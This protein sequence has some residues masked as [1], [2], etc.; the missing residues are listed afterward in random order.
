MKTVSTNSLLRTIGLMMGISMA[1]SIMACNRQD[2][3][4][5]ILH[6]ND[7][8][9]EVAGFAKMAYLRD[10]LQA[11]DTAYVGVVSSGDLFQGGIEGT[12]THGQQIVDIMRC[13]GY[14]A[15]VPGNHEFDYGTPRML[16]LFSQLGNEKVSCVNLSDRS[17]KFLFPNY[18]MHRYGRTKV[19]Y[20][21]VLTPTTMRDEKS[22]FITND[23]DTLYRLQTDEE[24]VRLTQEQV[25]SARRAGAKYVILLTHIGETD[26]PLTSVDLIQ[27]TYGVDAVLDGHTHSEIA[28][29][30]VK[31]LKG[32]DVPLTQTGT[33]FMN[34]GVV[35]IGRDGRVRT[36]L[37]PSGEIAGSS[38]SVQAVLDSIDVVNAPIKNQP[39]G[40]TEV[41]LTIMGDNGQRL[42]RKGETNGGNLA[43]D[44][45]R[46]ACGAQ[47]AF[48]NGGGI[49]NDYPIGEITFGQVINVQPF[50]NDYHVIEI[51]G[52]QLEQVV[53]FGCS[54]LKTENLAEN[55]KGELGDFV[56]PSGFR[57]TFS[58]P[59][60]KVLSLEV[61]N[62]TTGQYEPIQ[63]DK[64]YT[65]AVSQYSLGS[66]NDVMKNC[67]VLRYN[68]CV[69]NTA[70]IRYIQER[71]GGVVG[72]EYARPQ[73]RITIIR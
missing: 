63:P 60:D 3:P 36:Y 73:G 61:L 34:V 56:Q 1:W 58:V 42:V 39:V 9:C 6:D 62:E 16:E 44:A 15:V 52:R 10:A 18:V 48:V 53:A 2:K 41:R 51:T 49:R 14:D 8:H 30:M 4:I 37:K 66:Y 45:A 59:E 5:V 68:V 23:G 47:M 19:A 65:M 54:A 64:T 57:Y 55:K 40:R 22:A 43:A 38:K 72:Q 7:S 24:V 71:L 29:R 31:N 25:N 11:S 28:Q 33:K 21:G 17:G 70:T 26:V 46:W 27:K 13:V 32:I 67:N 12:L 35:Y 50:S 20:V 69:D